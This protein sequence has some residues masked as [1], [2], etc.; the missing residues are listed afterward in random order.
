MSAASEFVRNRSGL[1]GR[2]LPWQNGENSPGPNL[3]WKRQRRLH[4]KII[5]AV[6]ASDPAFCTQPVCNQ[7]ELVITVLFYNTGRRAYFAFAKKNIT[8][9]LWEAYKTFI[10]RFNP[11]GASKQ[12]VVHLHGGRFFAEE[13]PRGYPHIH[14]AG[15]W[16][17]TR[18][19]GCLFLLRT[20]RQC[21]KAGSRK[22]KADA[23]LLIM[24]SYRKFF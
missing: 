22:Q 8:E 19:D 9:L 12:A 2:L 11:D 15:F 24:G 18:G 3:A 1:I 5:C 14:R 10:L 6:S 23:Q 4:K 7:Q 16:R 21:F 13:G 20:F 17:C